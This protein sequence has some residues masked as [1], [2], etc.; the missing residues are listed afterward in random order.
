MRLLFIGNSITWHPVKEEIGW[1]HEWGM[2]ASSEE[3]DFVHIVMNKVRDVHPE[4]E[5][6]IAWAVA[7]EREYWDAVHLVAFREYLNFG[8][9]IIIIKINEN[10]TADNNKKYPYNVYY[11]RLLD[12]INPD[13]RAK[14]ILCTGFWKR[15]VLDRIVREIAD[16][17][18][19]SLV[20]LNHLD[21]D[22][23]KAQ[24]SYGDSAPANHPGDRG[25][26]AIADCIWSKLK[27]LI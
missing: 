7:W 19:H 18:G 15:G 21:I 8:A 4:A 12:Y 16:E 25:M 1:M 17:N 20:E 3:N 9:D 13:N 24:D 11:R 23:M 10:V 14:V 26:A 2:A 27:D 5:Y 6:R 22:E